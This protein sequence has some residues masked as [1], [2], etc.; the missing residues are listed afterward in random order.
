MKPIVGT[1]RVV[2]AGRVATRYPL[3]SS[4]NLGKAHFLQFLFEMLGKY[5][6]AGG[7]MAH[8]LVSSSL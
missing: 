8:M 4:C 6:L 2:L 7:S 3:S 1:W 5:H